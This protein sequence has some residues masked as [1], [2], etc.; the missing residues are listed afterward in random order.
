MNV[1]DPQQ[2]ELIPGPVVQLP[3]PHGLFHVQAWQEPGTGVEHLSLSSAAE[4]LEP[5]PVPLVRVHS[6]CLTG[7]VFGSYRCDC[8]EQLDDAL[9]QVQRHGGTVIYLRGQE[10]RGIGLA[11][12]LRAYALQESGADTVEANELLGLPVDARTYDAAAAILRI[13]GQNRIDLLSNNP[14]KTQRLRELGI[15]VRQTVPAEIPSRR[16]NIMYLRTKRDKMNH[17]LALGESYLVEPAQPS[18]PAAR[19]L[20]HEL[21]G[22]PA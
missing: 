7:D 2:F 22:N 15:D 4:P 17:L 9:A 6:E 1:P 18:D 10:G 3:T 19:A 12:K 13:L 21:P 11:N 8:G 14:V 16:E 5:G 20:P